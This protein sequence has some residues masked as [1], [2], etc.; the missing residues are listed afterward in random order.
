MPQLLPYPKPPE[1]PSP[2]EPPSSPPTKSIGASPR[3]A[4]LVENDESLLNFLR[5]SLTDEGYAVHPASNSEEGLRLYRDCGPFNVVLIDY[6]V[7]QNDGGNIDHWAPQT[8]GIELAVAIR[9]IN[10]SQK[11]VIAAFA[12]RNAGEVP[13]PRELMDI[14]LLIDTSNVQLRRLLEKIEVDRAME[15]L[16]PSE[17]LRLRQFAD[18]R[19]RGLGRAARGRTGEDLLSDAQLR[20]LIGAGATREGR[21]WNKHVDFVW[22]LTGAMRSISSCWNRQF[23]EKEKEPYLMK[24]PHLMSE[25]LKHD[26]EGQEQSPLD[27]VASEQAAADQSLI[28]KREEGRVLAM[29]KDDPEAT[30]VLQ[31]LLDGLKKNEI[32]S[33]HGFDEKKYAAVVKRILKLLGRKNGGSKG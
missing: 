23:K 28:E 3:S 12:Y 18:F 20:T 5:R 27:N 16:T 19:V 10:P 6:C 1:L 8:N 2:P 22:H 21:H 24:E 15:G 25:L 7:P 30:Q 32:M 14:P 17:L 9:E 29:F 33:R 26:A 11:I 4:L 31:G 13:R